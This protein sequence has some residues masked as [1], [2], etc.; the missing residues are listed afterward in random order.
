L[1]GALK[2]PLGS[3]T[4]VAD[5]ITLG[6]DSIVSVSGEGQLVPFGRT[7]ASGRRY[8]YDLGEGNQTIE[9]APQKRIELAGKDVEFKA[10]ATLDAFTVGQLLADTGGVAL[11][12]H[13]GRDN[14]ANIPTRYTSGTPSG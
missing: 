7:D 1:G 14:Y 11:I 12:V 5:K 2:A 3:I 9:T 13:A 4:L 8:I 6:E 10:G